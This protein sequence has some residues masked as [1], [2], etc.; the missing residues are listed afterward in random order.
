MGNRAIFKRC[1]VGRFLSF[2]FVLIFDIVDMVIEV[3]NQVRH[4]AGRVWVAMGQ[5][6]VQFHDRLEFVILML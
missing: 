6:G 5:V 4:G 2:C 1:G 3:V